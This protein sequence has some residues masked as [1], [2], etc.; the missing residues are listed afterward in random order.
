MKKQIKVCV[1]NNNIDNSGN[2]FSKECI[3]D[4][5]RQINSQT[6]EFGKIS[7]FTKVSDDIIFD[8]FDNSHRYLSARAY[9]NKLIVDIEL[10]DTPMGNYLKTYMEN[11]RITFGLRGYGNIDENRNISKYKLISINAI[12]NDSH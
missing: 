2:V 6:I 11:K 1:I 8:V 7:E 3:A 9:Y 10:L 12:I 5:A 4:I